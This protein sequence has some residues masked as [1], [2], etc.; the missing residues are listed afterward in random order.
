MSINTQPASWQNFSISTRIPCFFPSCLAFLESRRASLNFNPSQVSVSKQPGCLSPFAYP[1]VQQWMHTF[2]S[3]AFIFI[4]SAWLATFLS[5]D[6][7]FNKTYYVY[8]ATSLQKK[9]VSN[10]AGNFS[11]KTFHR[12][13]T[14]TKGNHSSL[15]ISVPLGFRISQTEQNILLLFSQRKIETKFM[16]FL[17]L[18]H[19]C[20]SYQSEQSCL[21]LNPCLSSFL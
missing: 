9:P 14:N 11:V 4:A 5:I 3:T 18:K 7:F 2:P 12:K 16:I 10:L 20:F 13:H 15:K 21:A 1:T 19:I 8:L 17:K 6:L